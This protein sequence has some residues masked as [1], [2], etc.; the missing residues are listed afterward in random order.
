MNDRD[1]LCR[2]IKHG[3]LLC[4]FAKSGAIHKFIHSSTA[5]MLSFKTFSLKKDFLI[6][7]IEKIFTVEIKRFYCFSKSL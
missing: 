5:K 7:S 4:D 2:W 3:I 1:D 6:S